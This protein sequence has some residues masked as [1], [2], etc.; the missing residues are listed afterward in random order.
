MVQIEVRVKPRS[1]RNAIEVVD[2]VVKVW[3]TAPPIDGQA[4]AAL[5]ELIAKKLGIAKSRVQ[6]IRGETSR[7]K[8][9]EI[10]GLSEEVVITTLSA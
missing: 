2:G 3:L 7:S 1:S 5:C 6:V 9:V 8:H 4:N 10:E